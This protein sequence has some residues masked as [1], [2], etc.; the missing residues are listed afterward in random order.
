M[1]YIIGKYNSHANLNMD[2]V[3]KQVKWMMEREI[4]NG[5]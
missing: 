1:Q 2:W 4:K 3:K 5:I